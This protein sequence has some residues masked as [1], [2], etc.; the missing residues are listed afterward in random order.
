MRSASAPR[1][2]QH[3]DFTL[4][5]QKESVPQIK[6]LKA[7]RHHQVPVGHGHLQVCRQKAEHLEFS[8]R[9][10]SVPAATRT[11]RRTKSLVSTSHC[12]ARLGCC[13]QHSPQLHHSIHKL[14]L[15][16]LALSGGAELPGDDEHGDAGRIEGE[17]IAE[18]L[19]PI[20]A[21][22]IFILGVYQGGI[23]EGNNPIRSFCVR[24][25]TA[26]FSPACVKDMNCRTLSLCEDFSLCCTRTG[27]GP[28]DTGAIRPGS[29][30]NNTQTHTETHT[31]THSE[32]HTSTGIQAPAKTARRS[33]TLYIKSTCSTQQGPQITT[34][35]T[36]GAEREA[37]PRAVSL[38]N[39]QHAT[40]HVPRATCHMPHA[41]CHVPH[42]TSSHQLQHRGTRTGLKRFLKP[43]TQKSARIQLL[44]RLHQPGPLWVLNDPRGAGGR[45]RVRL[46]PRRDHSAT[47]REE[48]RF[49]YRL[50][51]ARLAD[52]SH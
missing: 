27:Q 38:S 5:H 45:G 37:R 14:L 22:L 46:L 48:H 39:M 9:R 10:P 32:T 8:Q 3:P 35:V 31:K 18:L 11:D 13:P 24:Q 41:T 42:A 16:E 23:I 2:T 34:D 29:S 44:H 4:T 50:T 1:T 26:V 15:A 21:D 47:R 36:R 33:E 30:H 19:D 6:E 17:V 43:E 12:G 28:S 51:L 20:D 7:S 49:F 52:V 40:C 25:Y